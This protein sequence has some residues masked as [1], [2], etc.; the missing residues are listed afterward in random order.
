MD[1][2]KL[3]P[4]GATA[5]QQLLFQFLWRARNC[6][7]VI[8]VRDARTLIARFAAALVAQVRSAAMVV[9]FTYDETEKTA[10][11]KRLSRRARIG[12]V[13]RINGSSSWQAAA[14][15]L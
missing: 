4:P 15:R 7:R 1:R 9:C 2:I 10:I 13:A 3:K 11:Q 14:T 6:A 8:Q 12:I 5:S